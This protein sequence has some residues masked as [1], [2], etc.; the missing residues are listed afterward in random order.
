MLDGTVGG[1]LFASH[2]FGKIDV[3][4]ANKEIT[5]Q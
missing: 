3:I 4:G 2:D 5:V 1:A